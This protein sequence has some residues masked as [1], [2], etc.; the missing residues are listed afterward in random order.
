MRSSSAQSDIPVGTRQHEA[1]LRLSMAYAKLNLRE[2]VGV[3]DIESVERLI[4]VMYEAFGQSL[5][6]GSLQQQIFF[7]KKNTKQ[8]DAL[9]IWNSSKDEEGNVRLVKFQKALVEA[10]LQEDEAKRLIDGWE[11]NNILKLNKD[12]S[13]KRI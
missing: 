6:T 2:E 1:L 13:Y 5:D 8:H 12:G 10:G 7:D 9:Q 3:H 11:K 4:K